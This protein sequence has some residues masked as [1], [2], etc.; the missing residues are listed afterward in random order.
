VIGIQGSDERRIEYPGHSTRD[1]QKLSFAKI[2][3]AGEGLSGRTSEAPKIDCV[4]DLMENGVQLCQLYQIHN[5]QRRAAT[6]LPG[7]PSTGPVTDG[8]TA[9]DPSRSGDQRPPC[10][11][12]PHRSQQVNTVHPRHRRSFAAI[13]N[14]YTESQTSSCNGALPLAVL[15]GKKMPPDC[16]WTAKLEK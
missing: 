5:V 15:T 16:R 1:H 8:L 14:R 4:I 12:G 7:L 9:S 10:R 13:T 3:P 11:P 2:P 6:L